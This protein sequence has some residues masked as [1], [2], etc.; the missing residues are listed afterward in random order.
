MQY[1]TY[2]PGPPL[3]GL[4]AYLWALQDAPVHSTERLVPSGTLVLVFNLHMGAMRIHDAHTMACRQYSGA[5]VSGAYQRFFVID[6]RE[7]ASTVGVHF[8]PGGAWAFLGV[9]P[10]ELAD[11]H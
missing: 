4:V 10:G 1:Q 5:A 6:T 11:R 8:R 9:P 2:R 7:H 3:T